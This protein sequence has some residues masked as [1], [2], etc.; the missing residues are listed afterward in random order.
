MHGDSAAEVKRSSYEQSWIAQ[1]I[2]K[3]ARDQLRK[4]LLTCNEVQNCIREL[5]QTSR[6]DMYNN[7]KKTDQVNDD[8][9]F[10]PMVLVMDIMVMVMTVKVLAWDPVSETWNEAGRLVNGRK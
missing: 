1:K 9:N 4:T 5:P 10:F 8:A 6:Q 3:R 7:S 2:L